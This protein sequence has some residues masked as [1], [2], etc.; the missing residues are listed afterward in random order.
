MERKLQEVI[1][2]REWW[3]PGAIALLGCL[4]II[5]TF[6]AQQKP[7]T[8]TIQ[9]E[10]RQVV[11]P[12]VVTDGKG[13][14]VAGLK[15]G[16]FRIFEDA[17]EQQI[18]S[19]GTEVAEPPIA[20]SPTPSP[21]GPLGKHERSQIQPDS[22]SRI[23]RTYFV[24]L[25]TLFM[26][27]QSTN[28][29]QK[30]LEGLFQ[31]EQSTQSIYALATLDRD[32]RFIQSPTGERDHVLAAV[33]GKQMAQAFA[34]AGGL[35]LEQEETQL[36][37]LLEKYCGGGPC[38][39]IR[40]SDPKDRPMELEQIEHFAASVTMRRIFLTRTYLRNLRDVVNQMG[41][42]PGK[43]ILILISDGFDLLPGRTLYSLIAAYIGKPN[44][45]M[46]N[47]AQRLSSELE[48]VVRAATGNDVVIYSVH[49]RGLP[50]PTFGVFDATHEGRR[51]ARA[52]GGQVL[53]E[54]ISQMSLV[55][56]ARQDTMARLAEVTGGV[57]FRGNNDLAKGIRQ[58]FADEREYY[59]LAYAPSNREADGKFRKI[60]V[61]LKDK[62]L[63]VRAKQG[64]WAP[65]PPSTP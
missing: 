35:E 48:E 26:T 36:K 33:R 41:G 61:E 11:V 51:F 54:F 5:S 56:N 37:S 50:A 49:A 25:D 65:A 59:V 40:R 3:R 60:R 27:F 14:H 43:R 7:S 6:A 8:P 9:I 34:T 63:K 32:I 62:K 1:P 30:G 47:P 18:V 10:A 38:S 16:D 23:R 64:Y 39:G 42:Q 31:S 20:R 15:A 57:F 2:R 46:R 4:L 58:A 45:V 29:V 53:S 52:D 55:E 19:I 12:V 17:T 28:H 21:N 44:F 24:V 22:P 13:H